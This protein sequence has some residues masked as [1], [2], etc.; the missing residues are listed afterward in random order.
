MLKTMKLIKHNVKILINKQR[1]HFM[2]IT[3]FSKV[4]NLSSNTQ[5]FGRET[6]TL[7]S[8]LQ[9]RRISIDNASAQSMHHSFSN[10]FE[11]MM[12]DVAN[13]KLDIH[14]Q[15]NYSNQE[16]MFNLI[17]QVSDDEKTLM[18]GFTLFNNTVL[19][20]CPTAKIP[21]GAP[22]IGAKTAP[23]VGTANAKVLE[24]LA[25]CQSIRAIR[26]DGNCFLSSLTT[27]F[28]EKSVQEKA[29]ESFIDLISNDGIDASELKTELI[30]TLIDLQEYPSQLENVL[31]N[32][33]KILPFVSYFRQVAAKEM[34][35]H[36]GD[37]EAFFLADIEDI[38]QGNTKDQ[39]YEQLVDKY[40]L[41]MGVDFSQPM[42][43]AL[44]RKLN[45]PVNIIDPKIGAQGGIN[46]LDAQATSGTFCRNDVHYFVLYP[47]EGASPVALPVQRERHHADLPSPVQVSTVPVAPIRTT[48]ITV[49]FDAGYGNGL[50]IRGGG[51]E[52]SW[53]RGTELRNVGGDAWVF[54]TRSD[55]QNFEYKIL[56]NDEKWEVDNNHRAECGKK[57]EVFPRF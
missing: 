34:K 9:G 13:I 23:S 21:Y 53:D 57:E 52:M 51:P 32:N 37:F 10:A 22:C 31:Q 16:E 30:L 14:K 7:I 27:R 36:R 41:T 18:S 11:K 24:M 17:A 48:Q 40:V 20:Y 26:G 5:T 43:T 19:T 45:F 42:I 56:I 6:G 3:V 54:E 1:I 55:F 28:L 47:R 4:K 2:A 15:T 12:G 39:S 35:E 49:R 8:N 50:F 38:Y 25:G 29:I 44:C 46:I 33:Q